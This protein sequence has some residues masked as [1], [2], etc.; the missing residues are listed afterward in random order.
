MRVPLNDVC[1]LMATQ[2]SYS[3]Q[4]HT[5]SEPVN[6]HRRMFVPFRGGRGPIG[7]IGCQVEV[8]LLIILTIMYV[9]RNIFSTS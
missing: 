9:L 5:L 8:R 4:L 1:K 2:P 6:T 3:N 7:V